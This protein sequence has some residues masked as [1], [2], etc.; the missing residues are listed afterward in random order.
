MGEEIAVP[1]AQPR[2][3]FLRLF[4]V[5]SRVIGGKRTGRYSNEY[6]IGFHPQCQKVKK[7][8]RATNAG[9]MPK[10]WASGRTPL[11]PD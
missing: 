2:A 7:N 9:P 11:G 5:P 8:V 6:V 3:L 4:K 10:G 1:V